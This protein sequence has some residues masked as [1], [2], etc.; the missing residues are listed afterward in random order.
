MAAVASS[1]KKSSRRTRVIRV[2]AKMSL[3]ACVQPGN[4]R[5]CHSRREGVQRVGLA[6]L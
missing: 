4:F 3:V 2:R 5:G 6:H 1:A